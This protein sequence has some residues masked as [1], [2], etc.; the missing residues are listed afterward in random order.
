MFRK[1]FCLTF[2]RCP[3][4]K[5]DMLS[6]LKGCFASDSEINY[7]LVC[8]ELHADG[9]LHLHAFIQLKMSINLKDMTRFDFKLGEIVYHCEIEEATSVKNWINYVKKDGN[10]IDWGTNPLTG[11]KLTRK[12]L[13]ELVLHE[14]LVKLVDNGTINVKDLPRWN[15]A[16]ESYKMLHA[17]KRRINL[18]V[19]WYYGST[20]TG[21]TR[22]AE[23]E[24]GEDCW[25]SGKDLQWFDGYNGQKTAILDDLRSSSCDWGYLLRI[26]D[27]YPLSVPIKGGFAKW[28][29]EVIIITAP[30]LPEEMF[31]NRENGQIWDKIDQLKRRIKEYRNFD[32][33]PYNPTPDQ[34]EDDDSNTE[35]ADLLRSQEISRSGLP[36]LPM[37]SQSPALNENM[38]F[39]FSSPEDIGI[40][41]FISKGNLPSWKGS[42]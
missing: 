19:K 14:D 5:E 4:E 28:C 18:I 36:P 33:T 13:N 29:P 11:A 15:C 12:E 9:G 39:H 10:W 41:S 6:H 20:G 31:K 30:C 32:E 21:K 8:Q 2:P 23:D 38:N 42:R 27:I 24:G 25:R 1:N 35:I 17:T 37:P 7:L 40:N 34:S 3:I 26:L 22:K 16:K